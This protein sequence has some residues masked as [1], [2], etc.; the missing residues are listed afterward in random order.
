MVRVLLVDDD[1]MVRQLL[2]TILAQAGVS[3]VGDAS[4]GD[5]VTQAVQAH[6]PEVIIMDLRMQRVSGVE[7]IRRVKTMANPPGLIAVAPLDSADVILEEVQARADG[8]VAKDADPA[9]LVG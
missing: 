2:R 1:A 6:H 5:E 4:D 3:V 7:A 8:F 9:E